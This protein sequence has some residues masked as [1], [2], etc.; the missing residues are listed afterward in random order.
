MM[1]VMVMVVMMIDTY[2]MQRCLQLFQHS[3]LIGR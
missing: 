2:L 1:V 3:R